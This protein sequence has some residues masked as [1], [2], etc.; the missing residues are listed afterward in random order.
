MKR[1]DYAVALNQLKVGKEPKLNNSIKYDE[2]P[3]WVQGKDF[4]ELFLPYVKIIGDSREQD[5]WLEYA[6]KYYG[7]AFEWAKQD[8]KGK[9]ENLKEGD[10]TFKVVFGNKEYDFT[11]RVAY[12]RKGSVAEFYGNCTGYNKE[13]NTSDRD[14]IN[15]EFDR[16]NDKG[17]H[18]VVLMLE[19]GEKMTD[20]IGMEF[21]F[22]GEGGKL[23]KKNT[24]NT[25]YSTVMSW[26]QPNNKGFEIIQS[27]SRRKLFWIFLQ[28]CYY[29]FRNEIR[30]ECINKNLLEKGEENA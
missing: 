19:F 27:A 15:R 1:F 6:C 17:Y 2:I 29:Y 11:G 9:S 20:L 10:Y 25:L 13:K 4:F 5:K 23:I 18:K 21:E 14:R 16:F 3:Q 30:H 12:E 24:Y 26:K 28:D 7:I 8:K 22:R